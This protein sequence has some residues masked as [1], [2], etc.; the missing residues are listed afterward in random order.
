MGH[1]EVGALESLSEGQPRT[2][3]RRDNYEGQELGF[4]GPFN[5]EV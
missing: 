3:K 4:P 1:R 5:Q 2:K